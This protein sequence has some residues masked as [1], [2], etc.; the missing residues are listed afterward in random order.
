MRD[1]ASIFTQALSFVC[2]LV[3]CSPDLNVVCGDG[4]V[5]EAN[6]QCAAFLGPPSCHPSCDV[7]KDCGDSAPVCDRYGDFCRACF[8][9]D[10]DECQKRDPRKP[11]CANGRCAACRPPV[12]DK[13][14]QA[15][16]CLRLADTPNNSVCDAKTLS[17]R[18]CGRHSEC[19]SG[20]CA[21]DDN[22]PTPKGQCVPQDQI[23]VIDSFGCNHD[24]DVFCSMKKA[25]E[26]EPTR[27][28]FLARSGWSQSFTAPGSNKSLYVVGPLADVLAYQTPMPTVQIGQPKTGVVP[29]G[30]PGVMVRKGTVVLD[31]LYVANLGTGL[32]CQGPD[33]RLVVRRSL[34]TNNATAIYVGEGCTARVSDSW[35][36]RGSHGSAMVDE[37]R[38]GKVFV[39]DGGR[40]ELINSVVAGNG[41]F[42]AGGGAINV[43][44]VPPSGPRSFVMNS[45]FYAQETQLDLSR[46][47]YI[48]DMHCKVSVR[49]RFLFVNSLIH[50]GKAFDRA[51]LR[52]ALFQP[53]CQVELSHSA[54]NDDRVTDGVL[55]PEESF[56]LVNGPDRDL[57]IS[58]TDESAAPLRKGGVSRLEYKGEVF[59][60]PEFDFDG[61]PRPKDAISIGAFQADASP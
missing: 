39:V 43:L 22:E 8:A 37:P 57:H 25:I 33:T 44:N 53:A 27:R 41:T 54:T 21:I 51:R 26:A 20:I 45:T 40:L 28:Y 3:A 1:S 7:S 13:S 4:L 29:I 10:D 12:P 50:Y 59:V 18:P 9:S 34:F 23:A 30:G 58:P 2:L 31:G 60:A 24:M 14:R 15:D 52:E 11:V 56:P 32:L 48:S 49:D 55:L 5:C 47:A 19:R 36:G 17:C 46:A 42:R 6:E 38:N 16:E 35:F 61:K